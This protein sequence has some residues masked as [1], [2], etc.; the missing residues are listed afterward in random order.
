MLTGDY[1]WREVEA[2]YELAPILA[3]LNARMGVYA[4]FGN[5]DLWTEVDVVRA[6]LDEVRLPLLVNQWVPLTI[7]GGTLYLAGLDDG[8]SGNPDLG[9]ALEGAPHDAPVVLLYH[10]PDLADEVSKSGRVSL[11]LSGHSH[12][13]Q[14][15]F[16]GVGAVVDE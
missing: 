13:G 16:P 5:H 10:E 8:W 1:V 11:Q 12:G 15:R 2:I 9:A 4:A 7:N 3:G 14:I 6:G